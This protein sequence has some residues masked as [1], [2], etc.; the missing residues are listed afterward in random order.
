MVALLSLCVFHISR[1]LALLIE[2]NPRL[3]NLKQLA[4]WQCLRH[5]HGPP[6]KL[7]VAVVHPY[8][9]GAPIELAHGKSI[10]ICDQVSVLR[11]ATVNALE[12]ALL[13]RCP[14]HCRATV[15]SQLLNMI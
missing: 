4:L 15:T 5:R 12:R 3:V 14:Q 1:S 7:S 8:P 9:L 6:L 11:I 13:E 10:F 2:A